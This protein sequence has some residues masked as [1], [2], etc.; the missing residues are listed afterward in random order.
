MP[1][2]R[3]SPSWWH[4]LTEY[5][6]VWYKALGC[7]EQPGPPAPSLLLCPKCQVVSTNNSKLKTHQ[8][9]HFPERPERPVGHVS[10][11]LKRAYTVWHLESFK[12]SVYS[13][14]RITL[15]NIKNVDEEELAQKQHMSARL[16]GW[17]STL[18]KILVWRGKKKNYFLPQNYSMISSR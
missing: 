8:N 6:E 17:A 2:G 16:P 12:G 7:E 10:E 4:S 9:K 11:V 5:W 1:Q 3:V 15:R 14:A 13:T 18:F